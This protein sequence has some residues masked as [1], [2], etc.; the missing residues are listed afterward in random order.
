MPKYVL[1]L[2]LPSFGL[3]PNLRKISICCSVK[4]QNYSPLIWELYFHSCIIKIPVYIV[5]KEFYCF[6]KKMKNGIS[7]FQKR[8]KKNPKMN[9]SAYIISQN[10][11]YFLS[12]ILIFQQIIS[13]QI[14]NQASSQISTHKNVLCKHLTKITSFYNFR[15]KFRKI[16]YVYYLPGLSNACSLQLQHSYLVNPRKR[17]QRNP[18]Y[19][20][21]LKI[22]IVNVKK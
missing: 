16:K 17:K 22:F 7:C 8:Q 18:Q 21:L 4:V 10:R 14:E 19:R 20:Q 3:T 5:L 15:N 2:G 9:P 11:R 12:T 13:S 1:C 6:L